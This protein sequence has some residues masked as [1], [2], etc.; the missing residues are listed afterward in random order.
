MPTKVLPQFTFL[1]DV[2]GCMV[3]NIDGF[4]NDA[5]LEFIAA[6]KGNIADCAEITGRNATAF[7]A[8]FLRSAIKNQNVNWRNMGLQKVEAEIA[9]AL[10]KEITVCITND[11]LPGRKPGDYY[12]R[13]KVV[14]GSALAKADITQASAV[15]TGSGLGADDAQVISG[16][17]RFDKKAQVLSYL[18][19]LEVARRG[20]GV[21]IYIDDEPDNVRRVDEL[22]RD[23]AR[24]TRVVAALIDVEMGIGYN[25]QVLEFAAQAA[26]GSAEH[27]AYLRENTE[28]YQTFSNQFN[29]FKDL[30]VIDSKLSIEDFIAPFV[31]GDDYVG[32]IKK[33]IPALGIML[34]TYGQQEAD[35][36]AK[37]T[38]VANLLKSFEGFVAT[39]KDEEFARAIA[40]SEQTSG[41]GTRHFKAAPATF[42]AAP[43]EDTSRDEEFAREL[44]SSTGDSKIGSRHFK[45]DPPATSV[46]SPAATRPKTQK[47]PL[48]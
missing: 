13:F 20:G 39:G 38:R 15:I 9:R 37:G 35:S 45:A 32:A 12:K 16:D 21:A 41:M 4:Y 47:A 23:G 19:G 17:E 11:L 5:V 30:G 18:Q 6:N 2:D 24:P 33:T 46:R 48:I 44:A 3:S 29:R 7:G 31:V 28:N 1:V 36:I 40:L 10:G 25:N 22:S 43:P 14:E 8:R 27:L 42:S 34:D 26:N